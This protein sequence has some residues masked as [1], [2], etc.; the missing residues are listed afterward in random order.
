MWVF[1]LMC[2][3][4]QQEAGWCHWLLLCAAS[5]N[6]HYFPPSHI[7]KKPFVK[8]QEGQEAIISKMVFILLH[9]QEA[10]CE[11]SRRP[12]AII[13][14]MDWYPPILHFMQFWSC[15]LQRSHHPPLVFI[16]P[17]CQEAICEESRRPRSHNF[18]NGSILSYSS[19]HAIF[20]IL[21]ILP[22]FL[23]LS[24]CLQIWYTC[25]DEVVHAK[26]ESVKFFLKIQ[27]LQIF[28]KFWKFDHCALNHIASSGFPVGGL[29]YGLLSWSG[30][31]LSQT[32][33]H[34]H[35]DIWQ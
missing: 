20:N 26:Q 29:F 22:I 3:V 11:E 15:I 18:K 23:E 30:R 21:I 13:S 35:T 27:I 4:G 25:S 17:H 34:H 2:G 8:N 12:T 9:C 31:K 32:Q 19:F 6:L 7:A 16:L 24:D 1:C 33:H 14:R 10:I 5:K 28:V